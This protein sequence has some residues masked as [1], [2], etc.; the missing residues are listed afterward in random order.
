MHLSLLHCRQLLLTLYTA[1]KASSG[2][3][4][5]AIHTLLGQSLDEAASFIKDMDKGPV[6]LSQEKEMSTG[7]ISK[8][9][10]SLFSVILL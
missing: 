6:R 3:M 5:L 10:P 4:S 8:S 7:K 1:N 2:K 9:F